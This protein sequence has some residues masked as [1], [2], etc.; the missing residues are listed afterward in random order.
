MLFA[1][2]EMYVY[3]KEKA[4]KLKSLERKKE[5]TIAEEIS[6][7][8]K[9]MIAEGKVNEPFMVSIQGKERLMTPLEWSRLNNFPLFE[10]LLKKHHADPDKFYDEP[11][12]MKATLSGSIDTV[13]LLLA[14]G[15][16]VSVIAAERGSCLQSLL[17]L[18]SHFYSFDPTTF[19]QC[20]KVDT[21]IAL[22]L[23]KAGACSLNAL[24]VLQRPHV[25]W[26]GSRLI[27]TEYGKIMFDALQQRKKVLATLTWIFL[28]KIRTSTQARPTALPPIPLDAYKHI[29]NFEARFLLLDAAGQP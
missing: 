11:L 4:I 28:N 8:I 18:V 16:D 19:N 21:Q 12:L 17:G 10:E 5:L 26:E 15:A 6:N 23:V 3:A 20:I 9:A 2:H 13:K 25:A 22:L 29:L 27:D 14:A 7:K 1:P 24:H